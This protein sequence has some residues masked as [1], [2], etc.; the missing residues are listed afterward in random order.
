[1]MLLT[2]DI[3]TSINQKKEAVPILGP[4]RTFNWFENLPKVCQELFTDAVQISD[5]RKSISGKWDNILSAIHTA[6]SCTITQKELAQFFTPS[7]VALYAA[8]SL[9]DNYNMEIIFDPCVGHGSLLIATALVLSEKEQL[10][11]WDLVKKLHGSEIDRDTRMIAI[12]NIA[13]CLVNIS[14][15]LEINSVEAQLQKQIKLC[16]FMTYPNSKLSGLKIIV[17]P[18]YKEGSKGN[19]WIPIIEKLIDIDISSVSLIVPVAISSSKR[20]QF[21]RRKIFDKFEKISAFHHEI[22]PRPLF[23]GVEQRI[24]IISATRDS[25]MPHEYMTTGFLR[26]NAGERMLVWKALMTKLNKNECNNIFPKV[27]PLDFTFY[28]EFEFCENRVRLSEIPLNKESAKEVWVRT[29]GRY[30]LLAQYEKPIEITTK[31]KRLLIP[32]QIAPHFISAFQN[33][34]LLKWW[35]IFGDGRDISITSL[36]NNYGVR[37]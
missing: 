29:T 10:S 11:S 28:K 5:K 27:S 18:P 23:H 15:S 13:R 37:L 33:G 30:H 16:D 22:R 26:H 7:D 36:C 14:P 34:D 35:Q 24:S 19:A 2:N 17:N 12:K 1:M 32:T 6:P 21:L 3:P 8:F 4:H 9:L 20:T 31:W 25:A